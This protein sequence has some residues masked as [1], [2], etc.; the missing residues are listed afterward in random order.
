[1]Q[2]QIS[3]HVILLIASGILSSGLGYYS[4]ESEKLPL[5]NGNSS[6]SSESVRLFSGMQNP[7][8]VKISVDW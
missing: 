2:K 6:I 8:N 5:L 1:M 7:M 4:S 3:T